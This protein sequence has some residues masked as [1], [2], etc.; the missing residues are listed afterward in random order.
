MKVNSTD[1]LILRVHTRASQNFR[2]YL[3]HSVL[4]PEWPGVT[5]VGFSEG[6]LE[7]PQ[8]FSPL[9]LARAEGK[10]M[11]VLAR[12]AYCIGIRREVSLW[13][14]MVFLVPRNH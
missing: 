12:L 8:V 1:L 6:Y 2:G 5:L 14:P 7:N 10:Y 4:S 9:Y 13:C 11:G 3:P